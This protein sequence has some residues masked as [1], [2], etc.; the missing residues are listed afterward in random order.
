[1]KKII[2]NRFVR[3]LQVQNRSII[4]G[5]G[6]TKRKMKKS[7]KL[8]FNLSFLMAIP[9][10]TVEALD[11]SGITSALSD[12]FYSKVDSNEGTTTFRSLL[13]PF[14]GRTES[15]GSAY[16]GLCDDISYLQFNPAAASVQKETQLSV[17]HNQWIADSKMETIAFTTRKSNLGLGAYLSC[18]YVPFTEYNLF[19]ER[20]NG[21]YYTETTGGINIAY[22]FL[23]GYNFKGLAVGTTIKGS[24]RGMPDY[25]DN[26]TNSIIAGS[27]LEQSGLA[28]MADF[29]AMLQ[30]NFLKFYSSRDANLR[31]GVS[32]Q[33]AG[34]AFTG[35]GSSSGVILDDALPTM[36]ATGISF[37]FIKPVT[38]TMDFKLPINLL[39]GTI[40]K[41]YEGAG[42]QVQFT[43][44]LAFLAGFQFKGANPAFSTGFEFEVYKVR[45]NFNYT[46]DFTSSFNPINRISLSAKLLLGDRGRSELQSKVDELYQE[47]LQ[48][49]SQG[50]WQDAINKWEEVLEIDKR[51]DPAKLGIQTAK[52]QL[53]MFQ[54]IQDS[55]RFE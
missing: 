1:M 41:P 50:K 21:S 22:N 26:D 33:N 30:F 29:G 12:V 15:L 8:I 11:Y 9:F 39:D 43:D 13:I 19:G 4:D 34:A 6:L 2:Y 47:G 53:D 27:G 48:L 17:F 31:V 45:L 28:V 55:L 14:G 40:Y 16:T 10:S 18:F 5:T 25:T 24:W 38:L 54:K 3:K 52:M 44:F 42:V 46:L 37:K 51:F 49:Y 20:A 36:I 32:L 7:F 35:F 23:A